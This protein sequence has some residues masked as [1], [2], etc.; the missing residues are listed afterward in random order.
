MSGNGQPNIVGANKPVIVCDLE[1]LQPGAVPRPGCPSLTRRRHCCSPF[2]LPRK[3]KNIP[4][5]SS[6]C[7]VILLGKERKI[8]TPVKCEL[9][10]STS[11]K[12]KED[13]RES[14]Y[15]VFQCS[16]VVCMRRKAGIISDVL[17]R[18]V[19]LKQQAEVF[20][21]CRKSMA[22]SAKCFLLKSFSDYGY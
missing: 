17:C 14:G 6:I 13:E 12:G 4:E 18:I 15:S 20:W 9:R 19:R 7:S 22:G 5:H 21:N 3:P 11:V 10:N 16:Y 1:A 8:H 2:L